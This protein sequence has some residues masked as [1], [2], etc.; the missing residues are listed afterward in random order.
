MGLLRRARWSHSR[1]LA[2]PACA[3]DSG[4]HPCSFLES[5]LNLSSASLPRLPALCYS[6]RDVELISKASL[7]VTSHRFP[8]QECRAEQL[9]VSEVSCWNFMSC[10]IDQALEKFA[11]FLCFC[12]SACVSGFCC[13]W[14]DFL[15]LGFQLLLCMPSWFPVKSASWFSLS[16]VALSSLV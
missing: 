2:V 13:D 7:F 4:S 3:T 14:E 16:V 9:A 6:L 11:L 12:S 8:F 1:P 5:A 15:P 10:R